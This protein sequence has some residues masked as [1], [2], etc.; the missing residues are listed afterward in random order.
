M[1]TL[2]NE[3][4]T[5]QEFESI[6]ANGTDLQIDPDQ[7]YM[8]SWTLDTETHHI[9]MN[10]LRMILEDNYSNFVVGDAMI[11]YDQLKNAVPVDGRVSKEIECSGLSLTALS[12]VLYEIWNNEELHADKAKLHNFIN[13]LYGRLIE[14]D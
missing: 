8:L 6:L 4:I 1:G 7:R 5:M 14:L 11:F 10:V 9:I 3:A 2:K 12:I 13:G